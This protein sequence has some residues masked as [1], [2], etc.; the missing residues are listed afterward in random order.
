[1]NSKEQIIAKL[2]AA[3]FQHLPLQEEEMHHSSLLTRPK[4]KREDLE[5][6]FKEKFLALRGELFEA[7]HVSHA[8]A[9]LFECI[10]QLDGT[11]LAQKH[12]LIE[13]L[14]I[15]HQKLASRL[16]L[17]SELGMPSPTFA[18]AAASITVA[19]ALCARNGSILV[20][21]SSAGGRRLS[22]LPP[23]HIVV[24]KRKQISASLE[25]WLTS[26]KEDTAWSLASVISGPS[27]TADIEKILVLG[28]HGPKRLIL[29]LIS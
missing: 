10:E 14:C 15:Q 26:L 22:A 21:S 17:N 8:A 4:S 12:E 3:S 27:R 9:L 13:D 25:S 18:Q 5:L 16:E 1:M 20:R 28:A 7:E 24:A 23:L 19:D 29:I 11:V 6:C 2:E